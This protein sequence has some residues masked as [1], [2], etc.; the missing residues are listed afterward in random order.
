MRAVALSTGFA[1]T[2]L[3][4]KI[5]Q[6]ERCKGP[7]R[8][9]IVIGGGI[10]GTSAAYFLAK[11]NKDVVL[12]EKDSIGCQA[13]SLAAGTIDDRGFGRS[14]S[15]KDIL[16][17]GTARIYREV[18]EKYCPDA[19]LNTTGSL[20]LA[21]NAEEVKC[22][23]KLYERYLKLGHKVKLLQDH[24]EVVAAEPLARGGSAIAGVLF[25]S[26]AHVDPSEATHGMAAA[27]V[28]EG[29][30]VVEAQRALRISKTSSEPL[31]YSVSTSSGDVYYGENIVLCTGC[32][33]VELSRISF[34]YDLPVVPVKGQIWVTDQFPA[35]TL[36]HVIFGFGY[37]SSPFW[38]DRQNKAVLP[39]ST[40]H[41]AQ[42]ERLFQHVYGRQCADGTILCGGDRIPSLDGK[43]EYLV[44]DELVEENYQHI[45]SLLPAV[46]EK[47]GSYCC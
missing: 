10:A 21:A 24:K 2:L 16:S 46:G 20:F 23:I 31:V 45:V 1:A 29:A 14:K 34:N 30:V 39:R 8:D 47:I 27:A 3:S 28:A 5:V 38:K 41:S 7:V 25:E 42:G 22:A 4:C 19:C 43:M 18:F 15:W 33:D 35:N 17:H 37:D 36:S 40:T 9:V 6:T 32:H 11:A 44:D 26:G 12:L 13:S